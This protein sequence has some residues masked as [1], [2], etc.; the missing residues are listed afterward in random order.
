MKTSPIKY[1]NALEKFCK[2][3]GFQLNCHHP[4]VEDA[5]AKYNEHQKYSITITGNYNKVSNFMEGYTLYFSSPSLVN[6]NKTVKFSN[7]QDAFRT[8][9]NIRNAGAIFS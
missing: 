1:Y 2:D 9:L 4:K 5:Y 8:A 7:F 3:N 6:F